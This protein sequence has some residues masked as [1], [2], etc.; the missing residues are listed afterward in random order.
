MYI[1]VPSDHELHIKVKPKGGSKGRA[2]GTSR[3]PAK[4]SS[5]RADD[6][7]RRTSGGY[8]RLWDLGQISDGEGWADIDFKVIPT[9]AGTIDPAQNP[10]SMTDWDALRDLILSVPIEDWETTYRELTYAEAERYSLDLYAD[11]AVYPVARNNSRF[12]NYVDYLVGDTRWTPGGLNVPAPLTSVFFDS[13]GAFLIWEVG[14]G[15]TKWTLTPDYDDL[16]EGEQQIQ[17]NAKIFLVPRPVAP[18]SIAGSPTPEDVMF[19]P[20]RAMQ[21]SFW[22]DRNYDG[23]SY[24][25]FSTPG[26]SAPLDISDA[27]KLDLIDHLRDF[28]RGYSY[29]TTSYRS[30]VSDWPLHATTYAEVNID[31]LG[32][33]VLPPPMGEYDDGVLLAVVKQQGQTYYVWWNFGPSGYVN[34][35]TYDVTGLV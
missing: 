5:K 2:V 17:R 15:M 6:G 30:D 34:N 14:A 21:R 8:I 32:D 27:D 1:N 19:G 23:S 26:V 35:R 13:Y 4:R 33:D 16:D 3:G 7:R 28:A 20:Y 29:V 25:L 11:S 18:V 31:R 10:F 9:D 24:P 22:L 12:V